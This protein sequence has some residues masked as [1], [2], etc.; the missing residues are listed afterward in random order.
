[1]QP[2]RIRY[3]VPSD[4]EFLLKTWGREMKES[5]MF[6]GMPGR[7]F[8]NEFQAVMLALTQ[9]QQ[10]RVICDAKEPDVIY[11][12]VVGSWQ[13]QADTFLAHFA[14]VRPAFRRLG[15][16][17]AAML[18]MGYREGAEIVASAWNSYV[19]RFKLDCLIYNPFLIWKLAL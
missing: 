11:G 18:D 1:M 12:F 3:A 9:K 8:F 10:C 4:V 19:A 13:P 16:C 17:R 6:K 14:Y 7:L 15:M 5:G 2:Y